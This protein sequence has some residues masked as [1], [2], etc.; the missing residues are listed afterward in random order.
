VFARHWRRPGA[1]RARHRTVQHNAPLPDALGVQ[2]E[3]PE[4]NVPVLGGL[5]HAADRFDLA[6][7]QPTVFPEATLLHLVPALVMNVILSGPA[8][9]KFQTASGHSQS[10]MP[11]P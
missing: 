1:G 7:R 6:V 9:E 8:S 10:T 3:A 2:R 4:G 11:S 5:D